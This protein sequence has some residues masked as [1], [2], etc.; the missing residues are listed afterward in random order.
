MQNPQPN[1]KTVSY[2]GVGQDFRF[3]YFSELLKRRICAGKIN[4]RIGKLTDLVFRLSEPFPEAAGIYVEHGWGKPTE[5]IPWDRLVKIEDDAIFVRPPDDDRYPPFVDQVG[6]LLINRHLMGKTILDLDGRRVE[7]VNDVHLLES[8]NRMIIVHVDISFNG[9][10]RRLGLGK[11]R[12]LKEN[13]ISWKYV[14]PLSVEDATAGDTV[15]LSIT[16]NSMKDLPSEDL[17]DALEELSGQEREAFFSAL[18]RESAADALAEA[19]PRVQRQLIASLRQERAKAIL[20]ELSV[21]QLAD[22]FTVLP[23]DQ[24]I[25]LIKLVPSAEAARIKNI[26]SEREQNAADLMSKNF[27]TAGSGDRVAGVLNT[28]R[29]SRREIDEISYIYI[30]GPDK[31]LLGIVDIRE[32]L[33]APDQVTME[34][35]MT[36]PVVEAESTDEREDLEEMFAKYHYRMIPVVEENRLIGVVCYNDIMK[37]LVTRARG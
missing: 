29:S 13:F 37:G 16:R 8:H 34:S 10:L 4:N 6:W 36:T 17:A 26:L 12:W 14:Q 25:G 3:Y 1:K 20:S 22:L 18:D 32:L 33:L 24:M 2:P 15:S 7:V 28:I 19:E 9:F 5:F 23:R 27:V 31:T 11:F 35:I 21:A 30:V